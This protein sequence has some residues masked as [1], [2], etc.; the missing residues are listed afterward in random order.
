MEIVIAILA[1]STPLLYWWRFRD[2]PLDR[3]YGPYAYMGVFNSGYFKNGHRDVKPPL[4]HWGYWVWVTLTSRFG[5]SVRGRLRLWPT[6]MLSVAVFAMGLSY[7]ISA[8]ALA[9]MLI[10]PHLWPHM[11]NTEWLSISLTALALSLHNCPMV[12]LVSLGLLPLVNQKNAL[13]V[14]VLIWALGL[15]WGMA[16]MALIPGLLFVVWLFLVGDWRKIIL[17]LWFIPREMGKARTLRRNTLAQLHLLM[18]GLIKLAMVL[19][20]ADWRSPWFVVFLVCVV[21]TVSVKQVVPHHLILLTFPLALAVNPSGLW[22]IAWVILWMLQD[23]LIWLKPDLIY[24][25]TFRFRQGGHYGVLLDEGLEVVEWLKAN[26][27]PGETILVNG[28]ENQIYIEANRPGVC[29]DICEAPREADKIM[30]RVIVHCGN[31]AVPLDYTGY[32]P[33]LV[34][35]PGGLYTVTVRKALTL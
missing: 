1:A 25:L 19:A 14:P 21:L 2:T 4:I 7:P 24:P 10:S 22:F 35:A 8:L 23:F 3:D 12:A 30:P 32:E 15:S 28:F 6:L 27:A 17:Y 26:T 5:L 16:W 18:P 13:L 33:Q 31:S 20:I 9:L 11:A 34:S 29:M